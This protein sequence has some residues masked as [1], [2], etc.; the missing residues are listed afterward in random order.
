[1]HGNISIHDTESPGLSIT[2]NGDMKVELVTVDD[3][4]KKYNMRVGF[5]KADVE[6]LALKVLE[7]ARKT[8]EEDRP[9]LQISIYHNYEEFFLVREYIRQFPNYIIDFHSEND[10]PLSFCEVAIFAY[11]AEIEYSIYP[12]NYDNLS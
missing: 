5:I 4:R 2:W 1:M 6:G 7:G 3:E 11:P 12:N 8:I 10:N 9:V